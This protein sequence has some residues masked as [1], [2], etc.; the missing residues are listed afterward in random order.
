M[1]H[2]SFDKLRTRLEEHNAIYDQDDWRPSEQ[3]VNEMLM[4]LR[5]RPIH[6][7]ETHIGETIQVDP[8]T[9]GKKGS[10]LERFDLIPTGPLSELA[11]HYGKGAEKYEDRNWER[12]YRWSLSYAALQRHANLFWSGEDFD[13]ET[14]T[15]H[16]A[17]VA[18]HAMAL[19]EFG[20]THPELDDRS[21]S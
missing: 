10:K 15:H 18:F 2:Y 21:K 14:G 7:G 17:A 4:E 20:N 11:R 8:V 1:P 16:M 13:Q 6:V 12:G 9:G 3:E 5:E 19:I